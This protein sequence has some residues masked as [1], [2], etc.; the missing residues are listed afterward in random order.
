MTV[1]VCH[2]END[3]IVIDALRDRILG[4][5]VALD[6]VHPESQSIIRSP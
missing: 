5:T 3:V 1:A 4:R 2:R 6:V